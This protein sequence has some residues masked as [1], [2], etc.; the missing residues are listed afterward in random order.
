VPSDLNTSIT[1]NDE[2]FQF[3]QVYNYIDSC[4]LVL[5]FIFASRGFYHRSLATR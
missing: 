2:G 5:N 3:D 4:D 1:C